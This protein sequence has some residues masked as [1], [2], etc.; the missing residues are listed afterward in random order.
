MLNEVK[1]F[2]VVIWRSLPLSAPRCRRQNSSICFYL[3]CRLKFNFTDLVRNPQGVN[4]AAAHETQ[5]K[6]GVKKGNK[7]KWREMKLDNENW[8][9][10]GGGGDVYGLYLLKT[11]KTKSVHT[12]MSSLRHNLLGCVWIYR[13]YIYP[14]TAIVLAVWFCAAPVL[15][16]G[17]PVRNVGNSLTVALLVPKAAGQHYQLSLQLSVE[18]TPSRGHSDVIFKATTC[19]CSVFIN[20]L[21]SRGN[22]VNPDSV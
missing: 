7:E 16:A 1:P 3:I 13:I 8:S 5:M 12:C 11:Q 22:H 18:N 10:W 19:F 2:L 20:K 15:V 14:W 17:D 9:I 6:L 4:T 21:Q